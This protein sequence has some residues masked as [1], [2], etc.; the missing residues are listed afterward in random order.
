MDKENRLISM[1]NS[2]NVDIASKHKEFYDWLLLMVKLG[3][4]DKEE[5]KTEFKNRAVKES[6]YMQNLLSE[7]MK[8]Y[9]D[10]YILQGKFD[11]FKS[12]FLEIVKNEYH[13]IMTYLV[14][15]LII[16]FLKMI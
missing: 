1:S 6:E 8:L 2:T 11:R 7:N 5:E 15:C 16:C 14:F 13:S 10:M 3:S 12:K 4:S 9:S